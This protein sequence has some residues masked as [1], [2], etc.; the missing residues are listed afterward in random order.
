[1]AAAALSERAERRPV[2]PAALLAT[3][4]VAASTKNEGVVAG[5]LLAA[6]LLFARRPRSAAFASLGVGIAVIPWVV[7]RSLHS[8]GKQL[9]DFASTF[10]PGQVLDAVAE[11]AAEVVPSRAFGVA[12]LVALVC[13]FPTHKRLGV[14]AA[15]AV[16]VTAFVVSYGFSTRGVVWHVRTSFERI[17]F[18]PIALLVPEAAGAAADAFDALRKG[19]SL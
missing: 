2:A 14:L 5:L 6:L 1:M 19:R 13:A 3:V 9:T 11:I 15:V 8:G 16:Y 4:A 12:T 10:H 17:L 18:A 7:Y